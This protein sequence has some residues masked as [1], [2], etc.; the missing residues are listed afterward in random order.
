MTPR[1]RSVLKRNL[2]FALCLIAYSISGALLLRFYQYQ[3]NGDG[4]CYISIA[5]K[6]L[7]GDFSNAVNGY[8]GPLLSWLLVPFLLLGL[9]P[10]LASKLLSLIVGFLTIIGVRLL[11]HRFEISDSIRNVITIMLIPIVLYFAFS[12]I[13]PDLLIVCTLI[14]YMTVIF[15]RD[16]PDKKYNGGLCGII[17]ATAYLSKSFAFPFFIAHFLLLNLFHYLRSAAIEKKKSVLRHLVFGLATFSI[18]S[19]V[20]ITAIS[21]KYKEITIGNSARYNHAVQNPESPGYPRHVQDFFIP[22][23]ATAVS[24][25]ED[26]SCLKVKSWNVFESWDSFRYKLEIITKNITQLVLGRKSRFPLFMATIFAYILFFLPFNRSALESAAF[27]SLATIILYCAGYTLFIICE[28]FL[29]IVYILSILMAGHMFNR[30]FRKDFLNRARKSI[31]LALFVLFSVQMPLQY[32]CRHTNRGKEI[33]ELST[34]LSNYEIQGRIASN[35]RRYTLYL[36]YYLNANYYG[37]ARKNISEEEL[38]DEL[39][40]HDIDYYFQWGEY[41]NFEFLSDYKEVT[42][43]E[44]PDLRIYSLKERIKNSQQ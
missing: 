35:R 4:I 2:C 1:N 15:D 31:I 20:W 8:W 43:G 28:R 29:W 24:A 34:T 16:Y 33:Y 17:G 40:K 13:T 19:A 12:I 27:Y 6:Y 26:P 9:S 30:M 37:E 38:Q 5:Q 21:I 25:W 18:I 39:M 14:F 32:L 36:S 7:R 41:N 42:G 22:P 11:S 44:I 3:V 23:N 10:L